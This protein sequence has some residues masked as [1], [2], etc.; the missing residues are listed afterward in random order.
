MKTALLLTFANGQYPKEYT[1]KQD[2]RTQ[3]ALKDGALV[4]LRLWDSTGEEEY[5]SLRKLTYAQTDV[6]L[7][8]FSVVVPWTFDNIRKKWQ[9]EVEAL[10]PDCLCFLVGCEIDLIP[11]YPNNHVSREQA[12]DMARE[13]GFVE[14]FECSTFR[15][16]GVSA[17]FT[18]VASLLASRGS[19]QPKDKKKIWTLK[20]RRDSETPRPR[21]SSALGLASPA[22]SPSSPRA[23]SVGL[24]SSG[25]DLVT[26]KGSA[27]V[28]GPSSSSSPSLPLSSLSASASV[29]TTATSA[30]TSPSTSASASASATAS[31]PAPATSPAS[32]SQPTDQAS[33]TPRTYKPSILGSSIAPPPPSMRNLHAVMQPEP[34]QQPPPQQQQQPQQPQQPVI[35]QNSPVSQSGAASEE[36]LQPLHGPDLYSPRSVTLRSSSSSSSPVNSPKLPHLASD[37]LKGSGPVTTSTPNNNNNNTVLANEAG[38]TTSEA[39]SPISASEGVTLTREEVATWTVDDV[40]LWVGDRTEWKLTG[41]DALSRIAAA[42]R[43]NDVDGQVLLS[44]SEADLISVGIDSFGHRR[45]LALEIAKF[46]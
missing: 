25:T 20:K 6:V 17:L 30:S 40:C 13:L 7:F 4:E 31:A 11:K 8:L 29:S 9:P 23:S 33:T 14:Y 16:A 35:P 46:T 39:A 19:K 32:G 1:K 36:A 38:C 5:D 27:V 21:T 28:V 22:A 10:L 42:L 18:K 2:K 3:V 45:R 41:A 37:L 44:M 12:E 34:Q 15:N 24:M 43:S 26:P